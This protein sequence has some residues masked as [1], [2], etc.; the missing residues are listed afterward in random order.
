MSESSR[1]ADVVLPGTTWAEDEGVTA[2]SEGRVVKINKA[3]D[4]PGE[5]RED[6]WIIS[7]IARR[8]GRGKYFPFNSPREIFDELRVASKGGNADYYGISYEKI[9]R[10][11]GVFWP[12]PTEDHPGTPRLFEERFNHP[13]GKAK[14][15][16]VEYKPPAE[17]P[18]EEYPL[19]SD[20]RPR[21][22][23]VPLGEPDA[24]HRLSRPAVS[25]A[26]RRDSPR[27]GRAA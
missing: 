27:N 15:H 22:L 21:R 17:V 19:I 1:Y 2:N 11:N 6:W 18:D 25:G 3:A 12:C 14:F 10:Q 8:M 9:E 16:A 13:D 24:A 20:E 23:P 7:E 4:P 26:L 5:A